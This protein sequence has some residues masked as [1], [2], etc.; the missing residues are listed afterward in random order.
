MIVIGPNL[1]FLFLSMWHRE[2]QRSLRPFSLSCAEGLAFLNRTHTRNKDL[3]CSF[4]IKAICF[5][6]TKQDMQYN[7][8]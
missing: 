8:Y 3:D 5:R 7:Y 2:L 1:L 4:D 6:L